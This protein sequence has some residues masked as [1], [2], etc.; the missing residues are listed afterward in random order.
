[1]VIYMRS[2]P[3]HSFTQSVSLG[4]FYKRVDLLNKLNKCLSFLVS[5]LT[6]FSTLYKKMNVQT[7]GLAKFSII[8]D[9][10]LLNNG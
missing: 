9:T 10:V 3:D 8:Q 5:F 7:K 4:S 6:A 1:M 2:N